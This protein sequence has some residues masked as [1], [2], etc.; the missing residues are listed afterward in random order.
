MDICKDNNTIK[1]KTN[2]FTTLIFSMVIGPHR[3]IM[4]LKSCW[5]CCQLC[6]HQLTFPNLSKLVCVWSLHMVSMNLNPRLII[7]CCHLVTTN[8]AVSH[9]MNNDF[10]YIED[11][12]VHGFCYLP[13]NIVTP[14]VFLGFYSISRTRATISWPQTQW[15]ENLAPK[16]ENYN[17]YM[18]FLFSFSNHILYIHHVYHNIFSPTIEKPFIF[19]M[20]WLWGHVILPH[21]VVR[22]YNLSF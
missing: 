3:P 8:N 15:E 19:C 14:N 21:L 2:Q 16:A 9:Y 17:N 13:S 20:F 10:S 11:N 22:F 5:S 1:T 4:S 12:V 7:N 18:N 6:H